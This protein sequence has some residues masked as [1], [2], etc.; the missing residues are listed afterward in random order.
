MLIP[1][2]RITRLGASEPPTITTIGINPATLESVEELDEHDVDGPCVLITTMT[3]E[4]IRA[5][6]TV[7][8]IIA[9]TQGSGLQW[10]E[11]GASGTD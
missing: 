4:K 10:Q 3:D 11:Q 2:E 8:S 1:I 7:L 9:A 6:G 5:R